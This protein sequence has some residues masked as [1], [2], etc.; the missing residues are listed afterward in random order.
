MSEDLDIGGITSADLDVPDDPNVAID[1]P[2]DKQEEKAAEI[3]KSLFEDFDLQEDKADDKS[4]APAEE[5]VEDLE[6]DAP[7]IARQLKEKYPNIFKEIPALRK[8]LF[9]GPQVL[10]I[11]NTPEE[12]RT[13]Y[14]RIEAMDHVV[15]RTLDGDVGV[16]LDNLYE[17]DPGSIKNIVDNFLPTVYQKSP[18]LWKAAVAP[19]FSSAIRDMLKNAES[20]QDKNLFITAKNFSQ[21]IFGSPDPPEFNNRRASNE[22][23][24]EKQRLAE[25]NKQLQETLKSNFVAAIG[26][27]TVSTIEKEVG[28]RLD[29]KNVIPPAIRALIIQKAV[30][31]V[32]GK[33]SADPQHRARIA[34]LHGRAAKDGFSD[35]QRKPLIDAYL[36]AARAV[37]PGVVQKVR[38]ELVTKSGNGKQ[39]EAKKEDTRQRDTEGRYLSEN[40]LTPNKVNW[41]KYEKDADF[42]FADKV[43]VK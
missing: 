29:P 22:P 18:D 31:E 17:A 40:N 39:P 19:V 8:A 38:A 34:M 13:A 30:S 7:A 41:S 16:L 11:F 2:I 14:K 26:Q 6:P 3:D 25:S 4:K 32:R 33:L 28:D 20:R 9:A 42:L 15:S 24:P 27:A 37:I 43:A 12:A 21:Y 5:V 35:A 1:P 10:E 23:D 36:S